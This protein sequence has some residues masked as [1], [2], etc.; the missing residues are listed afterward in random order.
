MRSESMSNLELN[1]RLDV[2]GRSSTAAEIAQRHARALALLGDCEHRRCDAAVD[3]QLVPRLVARIKG[4]D[5]AGVYDLAEQ[6]DQDCIAVL[7]VATGVGSLIGPRIQG[8]GT[9]DL[10]RFQR[11]SAEQVPVDPAKGAEQ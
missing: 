8:Y 6:M 10:A 1:L 11:F 5:T 9:F 3:G 7:D 2:R 4:W